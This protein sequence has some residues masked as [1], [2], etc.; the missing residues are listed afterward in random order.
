MVDA[1]IQRS[2]SRWS[3]GDLGKWGVALQRDVGSSVPAALTSGPPCTV[4]RR[5]DSTLLAITG[6]RG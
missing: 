3:A 6:A 5:L 1:M 2:L 4:G